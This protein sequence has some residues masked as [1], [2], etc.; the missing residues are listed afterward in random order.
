MESDGG[1]P[2]LT[3]KIIENIMTPIVFQVVGGAGGPCPTPEV[4]ENIMIS[5]FFERWKVT[6]PL[7]STSQIIQNI[8]ITIVLLGRWEVTGVPLTPLSNQFPLHQIAQRAFMTLC[9]TRKVPSV[10]SEVETVTRNSEECK[11]E[12]PDDG[13]MDDA[14]EADGD[15]N[16]NDIRRVE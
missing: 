9:L 12:V 16:G 10:A 11:E 6:G 13:D 15:G 14:D 5:I 3:P 2:C 8:I 7:R 4:I 1:G